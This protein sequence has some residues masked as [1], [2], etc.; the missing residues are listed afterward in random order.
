[1]IGFFDEE[2]Q[3]MYNN[4]LDLV[5]HS[6]EINKILARPDIS[7]VYYPSIYDYYWLITRTYEV[8]NNDLPNISQRKFF[9]RARDKMKQ[10]LKSYGTSQLLSKV[11]KDDEENYYF[12]EFLGNAGNYSRGED[13]I[14]S[15]G[16]ALNSLINIWTIKTHVENKTMLIFEPDTPEEVKKTIRNT[17]NYILNNINSY[18]ALLDNAF[19][20][21]SVKGQST[22]IPYFYPTN[23]EKYINGTDI[24]DISDY[25]YLSIGVI[26]GTRYI[27]KEEFIKDLNKTFFGVKP[28]QNFTNFNENPF[29]FW[30]SPAMTYSVNLLALS[31]YL[32]LIN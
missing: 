32:K 6:L 15:S 21:G 3:Q 9:E 26:G 17:A 20:S 1:L 14:F 22:T 31:K 10:Y 29:P 5:L 27:E 7:L 13:R 16:L 4:T 28:P 2:I 25:K 11:E 19:F 24:P 30:S 12:E 18:F 8:L 23:V